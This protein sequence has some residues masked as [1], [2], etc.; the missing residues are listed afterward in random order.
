MEPA[1]EAKPSFSASFVALARAVFARAPDAYV[2]TRDTHAEALILPPMARVARA[3]SAAWR[4]GRPGA[5]LLRHGTFGIFEHI[6]L[7]ASAIDAA[8]SEGVDDG[9]RRL[10]ILGAGLDSRAYRLPALQ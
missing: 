4:L 8:I 5:A 3:I 9:S 7:R 10:V 2:G 1:P 6:A